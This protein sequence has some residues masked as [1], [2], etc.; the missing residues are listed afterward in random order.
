[1]VHQ[2]LCLA[3]A[4]DP[5][6]PHH[7]ILLHQSRQLLRS[8]VQQTAQTSWRKGQKTKLDSGP[9]R[10]SAQGILAMGC[11]GL[12]QSHLHYTKLPLPDSGPRTTV[13]GEPP[14]GSLTVHRKNLLTHPRHL[15]RAADNS[16]SPVFHPNRR[17]RIL[18][19][20]DHGAGWITEAPRSASDAFLVW[21]L[22]Y[23]PLIRALEH[24]EPRRKSNSNPC[25]LRRFDR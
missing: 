23:E 21:M 9:P 3:R 5:R 20:P 25:H 4:R 14:K 13:T 10:I 16:I 2:A 19:S 12:H 11:T 6:R 15:H 17:T 7:G 22:T 18:I 1:M 24:R 8:V